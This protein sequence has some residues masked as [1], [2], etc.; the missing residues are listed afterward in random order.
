MTQEEE[1]EEYEGMYDDLNLDEEEEKFGL[2]AEHD[3]DESSESDDGSERMSLPLQ[4][5]A[6]VSESP[7]Q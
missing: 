4:S 5:P 6:H 7:Q 1:F 3:E 2:A